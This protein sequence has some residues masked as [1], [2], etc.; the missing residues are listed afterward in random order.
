MDSQFY[1]NANSVIG[2]IV[3]GMCKGG[4]DFQN[5]EGFYRKPVRV[6]VFLF[7]P[8]RKHDL[9]YPYLHKIQEPQSSVQTCFNQFY[10]NWPIY[11]IIFSLEAPNY[12]L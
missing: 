11:R 8:I 4:I 12:C 5:F 3:H 9:S 1:N 7:M 10:P 2:D 6:K